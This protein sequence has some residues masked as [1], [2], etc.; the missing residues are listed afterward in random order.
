MSE[1]NFVPGRFHEFRATMKIHL[2]KIQAD[3]AEGSTLEY[4]GQTLRLSGVDHAYPELRAAIRSGWLVLPD[5]VSSY[6]PKAS[7]M[8]VRPALDK[9]KGS[10]STEIQRDETYVSPARKATVTDGVKME[11]KAFNPTLVRDTEGDGRSVG[12]A[13]K[14]AAETAKTPA[15]ASSEGELVAR[16]RTSVKGSF[17]VDGS[18][19]MNAGDDSGSDV[20]GVV[21]HIRGSRPVVTASESSASSVSGDEKVVGRL[22]APA[23]QRVTLEN[24]GDADRKINRL[25][26]SGR[27]VLAPSGKRDVAAMSGDTVEEI[28]AANEP[29]NRGRLLAEQARAQRLASLGVE[30]KAPEPPAREPVAE[31][32]SEPLEARPPK[33]IEDAVI[34]GDDLELAP[35]VRWNKK[36]HWKS[37][38]RLALQYRDRPEVLNLIRR[39]EVESVVKGIEAALAE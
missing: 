29:E 21:E 5:N 9:D 38:V 15:P 34:N 13:T 39:H 8:K 32:A 30:T 19:S 27:S 2:G 20:T 23:K 36:L 18:T 25:E 35:G 11:S 24:P 33:S 4:D 10:A 31:G 14:V 7:S 16:V 17:T 1:I 3:V 6:V 22:G 28:L 12:S 26:N 37:R